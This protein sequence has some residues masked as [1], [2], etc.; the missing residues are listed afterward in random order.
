M[1]HQHGTLADVRRSGEVVDT[2]SLG[3]HDHVCWSYT[4]RAELRPRVVDVLDRDM[5]RHPFS[6]MCVDRRADIP[7]AAAAEIACMHPFVRRGSAPF[8]LWAIGLLRLDGIVTE[9]A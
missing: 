4:D 6:A 8:R 7:E 5:A 3:A 1:D 9:V 2:A